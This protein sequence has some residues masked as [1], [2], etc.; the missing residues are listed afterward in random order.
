MPTA[1]VIDDALDFGSSGYILIEFENPGTVDHNQIWRKTASEYNGQWIKV[2]DPVDNVAAAHVGS[3]LD[4]NVSHGLQYS[5]RLIGVDSSGVVSASSNIVNA[6]IALSSAW[7]HAVHKNNRGGG[8]G[9]IFLNA[10]GD[11]DPA[12]DACA[13]ID[14]APFQQSRAL[15]SQ[16]RI[17]A[18]STT[19]SVG[20]G[21]IKHLQISVPAYNTFGTVDYRSKLRA[22]FRDDYYACLRTLL[23]D[24]YFGRLLPLSEKY[25]GPTAD[26]SFQLEV[27]SFDES[28]A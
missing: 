21:S 25:S 3:F 24:K 19:P 4:F 26:V 8:S 20:V 6:T 15:V 12:T 27:L 10:A 14:F 1:P 17:L 22:I 2:A 5:Y 18:N 23:G 28:V 9:G 11:V 7:L 16:R 13:L